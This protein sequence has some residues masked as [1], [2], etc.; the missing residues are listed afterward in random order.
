MVTFVSDYRNILSQIGEAAFREKYFVPVL[1]GR[2][3]LGEIV[4]RPFNRR[5]AVLR[6]NDITEAQSVDKLNDRV[7]AL[8]R[9]PASRDPYIAVGRAAEN[10]LVIPEYSISG[11]HCIF[12]YESRTLAVEDVGSLNGTMVGEIRIAPSTRVRLTSG[13]VLTLGRYQFSFLTGQGFLDYLIE[14][15]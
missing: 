4:Q 8:Q 10:D 6:V 1:I 9:K 5:T 15:K 2:G 12:S 7:W 13:D 3:V 14:N 11:K